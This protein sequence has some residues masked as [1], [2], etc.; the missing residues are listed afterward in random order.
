MAATAALSTSPRRLTSWASTTMVRCHMRLLCF[1]A[2]FRCT[3]QRCTMHM[4]SMHCGAGCREGLGVPPLHAASSNASFGIT[5]RPASSPTATLPL[6]LSVA[7]GTEQATAA[8]HLALICRSGDDPDGQRQRWKWR[9]RHQ[10]PE[11]AGAHSKTE[12]RAQDAEAPCTPSAVCTAPDLCAM[13][14][15]QRP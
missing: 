4:W 5:L 14:P 7:A 15:T 9:C 12:P 6:H 1:C 2:D 13:H 10:R 8:I 3:M 11:D